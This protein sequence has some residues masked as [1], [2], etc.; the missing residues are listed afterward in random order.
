M[1]FRRGE[2]RHAAD[3]ELNFEVTFIYHIRGVCDRLSILRQSQTHLFFALEE[4]LFTL[5]AHAVGFIHKT[6]RLNA[7]QHILRL[8]IIGRNI[9]HVVGGDAFCADLRGNLP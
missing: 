4:K 1:S 5:H 3:A 7:E 6:L 9:V 8:R 2:G